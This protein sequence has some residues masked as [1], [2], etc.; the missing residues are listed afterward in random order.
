MGSILKF[1]V[2]IVNKIHDYLNLILGRWMPNLT[3]K[4]LHFLVIGIVGLF[5]FI[6]T[7]YIF[8]KLSKYNISIIS[9]IYTFTVL[10]AI[11]FGIEIEQKITKRGNMEFAD[12]V[13]GLWGF[14]VL[15]GA[16]ILIR[17]LFHLI[18]STIGKY[19]H[20]NK[21]IS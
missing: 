16:Y 20:K 17:V 1:I 3:D 15:V 14:V 19:K 5:I 13:S 7:D 9:V 18:Y 6:L 11:V 12:I 2:L 10:I 8:K 4:D 21:N